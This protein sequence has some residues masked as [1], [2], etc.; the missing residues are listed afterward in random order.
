MALSDWRLVLSEILT[1][2]REITGAEM[3]NIQLLD[4]NGALRIEAQ[5]GF[6]SEFLTF[7]MPSMKPMQPP[8]EQRWQRASGSS[9]KT[10]KRV[11]FLREL[12]RYKYCLEQAFGR[13]SPR[14]LSL[15]PV[16]WLASSP[17]TTANPANQA[18]AT[19]V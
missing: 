8:A 6:D 4:Q 15:M 11:P 10:S 14:H 9:S 3:G 13:C 19:C 5:Y 12:R 1:A 7:L 17:H 18:S 16:R 2:A